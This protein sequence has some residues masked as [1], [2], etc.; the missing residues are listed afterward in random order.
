MLNSQGKCTVNYTCTG[1]IKWIYCNL[2]S[3]EFT[4]LVYS[5]LHVYRQYIETVRFTLNTEDEEITQKRLSTSSIKLK[6]LC[7]EPYL[8]STIFINN[9]LKFCNES[10]I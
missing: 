8:T 5:Q 4:G 2:T 7:I 6:K 1:S 10:K 3:A 9:K